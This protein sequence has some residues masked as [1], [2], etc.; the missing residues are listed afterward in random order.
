MPRPPR[1]R[2]RRLALTLLLTTGLVAALAAS[3]A[4]LAQRSPGVAPG[5]PGPR[6]TP[7]PRP[8]SPAVSQLFHITLVAASKTAGPGAGEAL[9]KAVAK[10]LDDIRDFLPYE[11]YQVVDAALVRATHEARVRLAGP[12]RAEYQVVMFFRP[13]LASAAGGPPAAYLIDRFE[14]RQEPSPAALQKEAQRGGEPAL[15][16][17]PPESNL[18]ASFRIA[19]GE[20]VVVGSSRLDGGDRAMI[21]LLT[22]VP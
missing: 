7:P 21:V 17:L 18:T 10:A 8:E 3:P 14:M 5:A 19:R 11:G 2:Q 1:R 12:G 15:A 20:T 16:P 22:A 9:P 6:A 4:L 13:E